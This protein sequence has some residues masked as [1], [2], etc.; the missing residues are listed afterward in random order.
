MPTSRRSRPPPRRAGARPAARVAE[1][2]QPLACRSTSAISSGSGTKPSGSWSSDANERRNSPAAVTQH[3][4]QRRSE[5]RRACRVR[6]SDVAGQSS[7]RILERLTGGDAPQS[8]HGRDTGDDRRRAR[9]R[10]AESEHAP[11]ER[12]RQR[13]VVFPRAQ[14]ADQQRTAPSRE[15]QR[16]RRTRHR[17]DQA[18]GE[19]HPRE[20]PA[21]S[22]KRHPH[23]ELAV[24]RQH[25]RHEQ[26]GD[27]ACRQRVAAVPR[28][29]SSR[30]AASRTRAR[31]DDLPVAA[32][33]RV[34]GRVR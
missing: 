23:A 2:A 31:S 20:S 11:I 3:Q 30:S 1:S 9:Q 15:D 14:L 18:L 28:P 25:A 4:R 27:V 8:E 12:E 29:R 32:S 7:T 26:A 10:H 13:D 34:N 16:Q 24:P 19:E 6:R 21:P 22:A 17:H 33:S 5:R